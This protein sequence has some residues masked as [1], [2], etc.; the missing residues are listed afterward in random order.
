MIKYT[1]NFRD[2]VT[3]LITKDMPSRSRDKLFKKIKN[4]KFKKIR[5]INKKIQV[6]NI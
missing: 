6:N 1:L 2:W 4:E 5:S 3:W